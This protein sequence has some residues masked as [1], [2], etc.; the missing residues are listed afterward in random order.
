MVESLFV[1]ESA[2]W[3]QELV[4]LEVKHLCGAH[5][6]GLVHES[7]PIVG[8]LL[9]SDYNHLLHGRKCTNQQPQR[10]RIW[11]LVDISIVFGREGFRHIE[12]V[13]CEEDVL[14]ARDLLDV[15]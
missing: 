3:G 13:K 11:K 14:E 8:Y 9:V 4:N 1:H 10:W 7:R 6:L 15:L 2:P 12:L 5:K